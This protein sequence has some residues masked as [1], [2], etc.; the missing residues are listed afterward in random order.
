MLRNDLTLVKKYR[1]YN[2][3]DTAFIDISYFTTPPTVNGET[4]LPRK[5]FLLSL[6]SL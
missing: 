1:Y 2:K 3:N 5:L 4:K 6:F